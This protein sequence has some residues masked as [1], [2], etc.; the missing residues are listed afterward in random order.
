MGRTD[1]PNRFS[2]LG[3]ISRMGGAPKRHWVITI[4]SVIEQC[5]AG[6]LCQTKFRVL[7]DGL[8]IAKEPWINWSLGV[9]VSAVTG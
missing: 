9:R 8:D 7:P 3:R 2:W 5:T 6:I 4:E 1:F